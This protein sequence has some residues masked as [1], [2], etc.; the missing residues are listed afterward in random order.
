MGAFTDKEDALNLRCFEQKRRFGL[1]LLY[2]VNRYANALSKA[3][4]CPQNADLSCAAGDT[5][6]ANPLFAGGRSP[7]LVSATVITGV[8]WEDIARNP[9]STQNVS[10]MS[11]LEL[12]SKN[13]FNMIAGNPASYKAPTDPLMKESIDPRSGKNPVTGDAIAPPSAGVLANPINGHEYDIPARNDLQ[14]ACIFPLA[15]PKQSGYDCGMFGQPMASPNKPLCQNPQ[16]GTYST[17]Q[18]F[19]KAYPGLRQLAVIHALGTRGVT[20]SICPAVTDPTSADFGY[21][22]AA[23]AIIERLNRMLE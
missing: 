9:A 19:A 23:R 18:Y 11:G 10:F 14:Y 13:R 7:T 5:P 3:K 22:P 2:P 8:P 21:R 6:V 17:T 16:G 1:D 4:I 12:A 15:T 20:A